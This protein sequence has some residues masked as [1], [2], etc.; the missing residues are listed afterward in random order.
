MAT[1][2]K[3]ITFVTEAGGFIGTELVKVLSGRGHE[4]FGLVRSAEAADRVR[5]AGG[6]AVMGDLLEAGLWQDEAPAD[7]V[8]HLPP[9]SPLGRR[10]TRRR[11]ASLTRGRVAMD[12]HLLDAVAAGATR[13]IVYVADASYY[14]A[15][16]RPITEDEPARPCAWGRC[17]APALDR[18]DGYLVAG[19]PIVTAFPGRVFGNG[20]WLRRCVVE[21]VLA[22]R[23]VLQLGTTGP[24]VSYI[25]VHDCVRALVHLAEHGEEGSR[26]FLANDHPIRRH[27]FE[28]SFAR[29]AGRRL[30]VWRL[31]K[32]AARVVV[33]P[34][35]ADYVRADAV[36]S[37]VRLRG[38]GFRFRYPALEEGLQQVLGALHE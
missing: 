30:R 10:L 36:L 6:T 34:V 7:W 23:R 9:G 17:L 22:G 31:P 12:A 15:A 25:H 24:W 8:F 20:S 26:Y 5:R 2:S 32:A 21:P 35:L 13:R 14:G 33:G 37:N 28:E 18:L 38:T 3:A 11:A 1:G 4:V 16:Q 27:E 29:L 19:L